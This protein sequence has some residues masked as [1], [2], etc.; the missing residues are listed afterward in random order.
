MDKV[1]QEIIKKAKKDKKVLAVALFGSTARGE[2][3]PRDIDVCIFL[4][5]NVFIKDDL[6]DIQLKYTPFSEKYDVQVFQALPLY[7]QSEILKDAKFL[8]VKNQD[9][10]YDL[11]FTSIK[12]FEDFKPYY[13]AHIE[14]I[15]SGA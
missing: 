1:L 8:L 9:A 3:H 4:K 14:A 2:K 12:E 10:L 13:N 11:S 6:F 15:L 7:I 5:P